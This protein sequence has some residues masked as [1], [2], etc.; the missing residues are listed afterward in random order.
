MTPITSYSKVLIYRYYRLVISITGDS[1][2]NKGGLAATAHKRVIALIIIAILM[3][4]AG[5]SLFYQGQTSNALKQIVV[6]AGSAASPVY[7]E[8]DPM[9][10]AKTG[11][12]IELHLGGSGS[13][14]SSMQIA[15]TGDIYIPGSPDYLL[16]ANKSEIVNLNTTQPKIL[17]YLVS[18]IIVQKG[19]P[20]NITTLE[21]LTKPGISIAI[22]DPES[23]CVG[24]YAK[25]LLETNNL[26]DTVSPNIV[27]YA[28]SCE[29]TA[30]LIPTKAVDA[31]IGWHVFYNWT[32]DKAD[33]VW[34]APTQIPKISYIAGA[35]SVFAADK[36]TAQKF[37]DF[38]A[39]S[40]ASAIWAKYGYFATEQQAKVHAPNAI[41]EP[42][43]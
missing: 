34:I 42:V 32:P 13:L 5:A 27:T 1:M 16:K 19:N 3:S 43:G 14:L 37:L 6:F 40:D 22:G 17:A 28:Q 20:K 39:S 7:N 30:A 4:A 2:K 9:F 29:A 18:A 21:D 33:I 25:E 38:L 11:I 12:K 41:I 8:A 24:L 36:T 31:V 35:V 26:W 10:E 15:K 23:V